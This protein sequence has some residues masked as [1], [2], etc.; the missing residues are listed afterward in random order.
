MRRAVA[1]ALL[2]AVLAVGCQGVRQDVSR[3]GGEEP[4]VR[5]RR[6]FASAGLLLAAPHASWAQEFKDA[7]ANGDG[8]VDRQ[9]YMMAARRD[10]LGSDLDFNDEMKQDAY[11][12]FRR[13][14]D[15]SDLDGDGVLNGAEME[16]LAGL[17]ARESQ[18]GFRKATPREES[19]DADF[20]GEKFTALLE[21]Y[22][23][24]GDKR[25][26]KAEFATAA[27]QS[28]FG[29]E[30]PHESLAQPDL[31]SRIE[32]VFVKADVD[33][34]DYLNMRQMQFACFLLHGLVTEEIASAIYLAVDNNADGAIYFEEIVEAAHGPGDSIVEDLL[35][36]FAA[37][38]MDSNGWLDADEV[39]VL[40]ALAL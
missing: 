22:D 36:H 28:V 37:A 29:T 7:D 30:S 35:E 34:D 9:E 5:R 25:L 19:L 6:F 26:S 12:I 23:A 15:V 3:L 11:H 8:F 21:H 17:A 38:D 2:S 32:E 27:M 16:F 1:Y 4:K 40:A 18:I 24:N 14:Y 20:S 39:K 13:V 33:A 31:V 10:L